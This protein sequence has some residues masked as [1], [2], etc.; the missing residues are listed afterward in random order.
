[1]YSFEKRSPARSVWV[2][3]AETRSARTRSPRR[4]PF[5]GADVP[6]LVVDVFTRE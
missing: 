2:S 6:L 4:E 5:G 3:P 1:M